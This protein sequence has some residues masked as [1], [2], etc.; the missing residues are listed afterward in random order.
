V[1]SGFRRHGRRALGDIQCNE[2]HEG[3]KITLIYFL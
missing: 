2:G 1:G 3:L